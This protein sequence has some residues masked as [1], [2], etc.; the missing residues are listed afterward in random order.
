MSSGLLV[1][2]APSPIWL[3]LL[4]LPYFHRNNQISQFRVSACA[5]FGQIRPND[6]EW[7]CYLWG[8]EQ[9]SWHSF[10]FIVH[11]GIISFFGFFQMGVLLEHTAPLGFPR[12]PLLQLIII[13]LTVHLSRHVPPEHLHEGKLAMMI[14]QIARVSWNSYHLFD[15]GK[16]RSCPCHTIR[17]LDLALWNLP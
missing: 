15:V 1:M 13:L 10:S 4:Y 12:A 17:K 5:N 6:M 14:Q 7:P 3:I 2:R 11:H 16:K 9:C 8:T